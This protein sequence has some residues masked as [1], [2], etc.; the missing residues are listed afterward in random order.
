VWDGVRP[1][2]TDVIVNEGVKHYRRAGCD[3]V[4]GYGGGSSMDAAK[5]IAL[6]AL[7]GEE[8][9]HPY[10]P[11]ELKPVPGMVPYIAV[12]TTSGT[13]S[14]V[15]P[16]SVISDTRNN[17]KPG[18][19]HPNFNPHVAVVDPEL[20]LSNPPGLTASA[21]VDAFIHAL[22]GYTCRDGSVI[23]DALNLCAVELAVNYLPRAVYNGDDMQARIKMSEASVTAG[24]A[25]PR[26]K[27]YHG[28]MIGHMLGAMH[29]SPH[30]FSCMVCL[31][32]L[33]EHNL[34]AIQ[35]KLIKVGTLFGL[36]PEDGTPREIAMAA[37]EEIAAFAD[38]VG[39]PTLRELTGGDESTIE[40]WVEGFKLMPERPWAPRPINEN[41]ARW[42]FERSLD[43]YLS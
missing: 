40:Q 33:L 15:T 41:D 7:T 12:P 10:M 19:N 14:E 6:L 28:H 38:S 8:S 24:V 29:H 31:P 25:F 2:P 39:T 11:P 30:G 27:L 36:T 35:E 26:S 3:G 43:G 17:S 5:S 18:L 34:P 22:E 9:I 32:A 13:G 37:I 16:V 20:T 42:I 23:T 4:I 1:D 21:G